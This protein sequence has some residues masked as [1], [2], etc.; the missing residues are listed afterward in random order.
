MWRSLGRAEKV[1]TNPR[2][3][4]VLAEIEIGPHP[5]HKSEIP[6]LSQVFGSSLCKYVL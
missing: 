2:K 3:V 4:I 5:E 1:L 6:D